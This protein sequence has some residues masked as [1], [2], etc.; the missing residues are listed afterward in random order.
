MVS[1]LSTHP[2]QFKIVKRNSLYYNQYQYSAQFFLKEASCLR[3]LDHSKIEKTMAFRAAW[4]VNRVQPVDKEAVHKTCD[5]LLAI[6]NPF[7]TSISYNWIYFYTNHVADIHDL[8]NTGPMSCIGDITS[9]EITDPKHTIGLKDPKHVFRTYIKSHKPTT[10]QNECLRQFLKNNKKELK[11]STSL[12]N[13][14]TP[15]NRRFWASDYFF[16]DHNDMRMVTA[17]A[18]INPALIRKTLPIVQ[19]NS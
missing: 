18:L 19:V 7:K 8:R 14:L 13:F 11:P 9:V 2:Q 15:K 5:L 1:S 10:E 12:M 17:L 16:I 6:K 3:E 4:T